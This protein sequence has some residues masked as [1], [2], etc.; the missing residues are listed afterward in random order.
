MNVS[1]GT[2]MLVLSLLYNSMQAQTGD[3]T[4]RQALDQPNEWYSSDDA[5]RIAENVLLY[6]LPNG[7]W[8]KNVDM[9]KTLDGTAIAS[10]KDEQQI[11]GSELSRTTIDNGATYRQMKFLARVYAQTVDERYSNSF[12]KGI[13]YLLEAQYDNGGWPQFYP[14]RD[15]YYSNVTF[16]DGAMIG[17]MEI[18]QDIANGKYDFIDV[19]RQK[20]C[21]RAID[22]GIKL[23]IDTQI[24]EDG[25]PTAWCAQY[26]PMT[27]EPA[28]ARS[29]EPISISGAESVGIV[30]FLMD[31]KDPD[32]DLIH[33]VESAIQ[34]FEEVSIKGV[35]VIEVTDP[36]L[37]RGF[38][39]KVIKDPEA[40]Q[41]WAR[42]YEI[43][44]NRPIFLGRDGIVH[45]DLAEIEYERRVG[46]RW[47]GDWAQSL[48]D[49]E[50]PRWEEN[51]A[52]LK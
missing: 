20:K 32:K 39:R 17:V 43:G 51:I 36:T 3:I 42:F 23:I 18:L 1:V 49:E 28:S 2:L 50:Y 45:Y 7:G 46:Y 10:I 37:P 24:E 5:I 25:K 34:W 40:K 52:R 9:A 13:D 11:D 16:N 21:Q 41:L 4:W 35:R 48:I 15:G 44:T 47:L 27:L 22:K 12:S 19:G 26:D 31:V 6:Q 30:R 33:A 38:D 8:P 14:L 29:Y